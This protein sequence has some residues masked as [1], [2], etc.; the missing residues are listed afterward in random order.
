MIVYGGAIADGN[1]HTHHDLPVLLAGGGG[2]KLTP[3]RYLQ[4]PE[5]PMSNMFV[6][7]LDHMGV[8]VESFGDSN[9]RTDTI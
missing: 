7:M 6:T 9:G 1:R 3:G 2:G 8:Q 4:L 5:Q